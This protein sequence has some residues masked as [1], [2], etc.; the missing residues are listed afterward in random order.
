MV[1]CYLGT[2]VHEYNLTMVPR[3]N[4][5][6]FLCH[7]CIPRYRGTVVLRFHGTMDHHGLAWHHEIRAPLCHLTMVYHGNIIRSYRTTVGRC[8]RAFALPARMSLARPQ[9]LPLPIFYWPL[10]SN[11]AGRFLGQILNSMLFGP[12][13]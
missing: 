13:F 12:R 5:T 8:H 1:R 4:S 3:H 2:L 9:E 7:D 10:D 11:L 6:M